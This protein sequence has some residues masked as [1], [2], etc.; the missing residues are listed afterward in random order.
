MDNRIQKFLPFQGQPVSPLTRTI[1][2][3]LF[4]CAIALR[5]FFVF[6]TPLFMDQASEVIRPFNDEYP[7]LKYSLY[8]K[9]NRD[10]PVN[11][12]ILDL[13]N[14]VVW[15]FNEFEYA[16]PPLYY[17]LNLP[18]VTF[19]N[20]IIATR[21]FSVVLSG[22]T[23]WLAVLTVI[24][25]F[26]KKDV[27]A[28]TAM[29]LLGFHP[30]LVRIGSSVANDNLA[31]LL[32]T[33]LF[34]LLHSDRDVK[35]IWMWGLLIGL[36]IL[37]K[38]SFLIWIVFLSV[39]WIV[40][41]RGS[42]ALKR[43]LLITLVALSISGLWLI[44]NELVYGDWSG[45]VGGSGPRGKYLSS[46]SLYVLKDFVTSAIRFS[47]FPIAEERADP[48]WFVE[49]FA[50]FLLLSILFQ[51][52]RIAAAFESA[53]M[54]SEL[55]LFNVVNLL[56]FI[57]ANLHWNF[58]ETRLLFIGLLPLT[59]IVLASFVENFGRRAPFVAIISN[60]ICLVSLW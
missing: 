7:H 10:F 50:L 3:V 19:S 2:Q 48:L 40:M 29:A 39:R 20:P 12:R 55:M 44:R 8:L 53:P 35:R 49:G 54:F 38:I 51:Y 13:R 5:C 36:G 15:I 1:L 17:V 46:G 27:I 58:S 31:W 33:I 30:V 16:Q 21:L 4:I 60:G 9:Q 28:L 37:T 52:K 22:V 26:R 45:I 18:F 34:L 25:V 56:L 41:R 14:P 24:R 32:S 42:E 11:T 47:F 57:Y 6:Q 59:G 43:L 23:L